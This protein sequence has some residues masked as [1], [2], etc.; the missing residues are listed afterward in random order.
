MYKLRDYQ[1]QTLADIKE[2]IRGKHKNICVYA[3][4]GAGKTVMFCEIAR[5][6][7]EKNPEVEV[8][9]VVDRT[10]LIDQT[11]NKLVS[12]GIVPR[13]IHGSSIY[14]TYNLP[15][16][17]LVT[18]IQT[19]NNRLKKNPEYLPETIKLIIVDE[20][21]HSYVSR[22][23]PHKS[24]YARLFSWSKA[25]NSFVFGFTA[26][27]ERLSKKESLNEIYST[28]VL[29]SS[30]LELLSAGQLCKW[31]VYAQPSKHL[32]EQLSSLDISM[33]D[34]D[35][36]GLGQVM[37]SS[38]MVSYAIT[39]WLNLARQLSRNP[40]TICFAV[41]KNHADLLQREFIKQGISAAVVVDNTSLK[42]RNWLYSE[43]S[44]GQLTVLISV[45]VLTEGFDVPNVE[46]GLMV[47]P[48]ASI[49]LYIQQ[50]GRILR[51]SPG[52][53]KAILLDITANYAKHGCPSEY[54]PYEAFY[55]NASLK[56]PGEPLT[57][58]CP[59]CENT[60][61][62]QVRVCPYCSY[63]FPIKL[64]EYVPTEASLVNTVASLSYQKFNS[65]NTP[66]GF[67]Q[68]HLVTALNRGYNL[69]WARMKFK[70]KFNRYPTKEEVDFSLFGT[71]PTPEQSE[72]FLQAL[73]LISRTRQK[74]VKWVAKWAQSQTNLQIDT[75]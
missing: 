28:L 21:H 50:F 3:P 43:L 19:L 55:K 72:T 66:R 60:M 75:K 45:G 14:N 67:M 33:G 18:S 57:K 59:E 70:D 6:A 62:I 9:I 10:V 23:H 68:N 42:E 54:N 46:V 30:F 12:L 22:Q 5:R 61:P 36:K 15:S 16:K 11:V 74:D 37:C 49:G 35:Q 51:N 58:D 32:E 52:K 69:D 39:Q 53:S 1:E 41:N 38:H 27:P 34:Y 13:V 31:E 2:A 65:I 40:S 17:I 8:L 71:T 56:E 44:T 26:T 29:S 4:T 24:R 7:I 64:R 47:R 48:T 25:N 73:W 63:R 20:C